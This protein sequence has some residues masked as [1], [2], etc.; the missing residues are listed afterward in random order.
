MKIFMHIFSATKLYAIP[1]YSKK[2]S[3]KSKKKIHELLK[4]L[5]SLCSRNYQNVK[6]RLDFFRI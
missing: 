1:L 5:L 2:M 4:V 3:L 6:L